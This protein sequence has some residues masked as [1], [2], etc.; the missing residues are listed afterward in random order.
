MTGFVGAF[1]SEVRKYTTTKT[2]WILLIVAFLGAALYAVVYGIIPAT[3]R[4]LGVAEADTDIYTE[5][6]TVAAIYNG[7][8]SLTRILALVAGVFAMGNEYRH[9]TM[10][11]AYLATPR[12]RV[13][14]AAKTAAVLLL[15]LVYGIA[16]AIAGFVVALPLVGLFGG[17]L[18]LGSPDVWRAVVLGVVSIA[19]WTLMGMGL[20]ILIPNMVVA[21]IIGIAFAYLVEPTVSLVLALQDWWL[22][23]NLLPSGAT[24]VMVGLSGN[25]LMMGPSTAFPWW[26]AALVLLGWAVIPG[27]IGAVLTVRKD[28]NG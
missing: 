19:L 27:G 17:S 7:G 11:L 4:L 15:G 18:Q 9:R 16:S 3:P 14:V 20:G 25:A 21:M 2:W 23:L 6:G 13:V 5:P 24:S 1:R 10:G 22:P 8:N 28:V 26:G 12:R